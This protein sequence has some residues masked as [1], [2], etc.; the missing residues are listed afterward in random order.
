MARGTTLGRLVTMLREECGHATSAALAQNQ[1]PHVK[2]VL[3]RIQE[4]LWTDH[5]WEHLK[6]RRD[7]PLMAGQR[8]YS[9]PTD[10]AFERI[11]ALKVEVQ[12]NEQFQPVEYGIGSEQYNVSNPASDDRDAPVRRWQHY[13]GE[14]GE[15]ASNQYEVWPMPEADDEQIL[16]FHGIRK[17]P[18]LV[19]DADRAALDDNLIVLFAAV[20]FLKDEDAKKKQAAASQLYARL[21]GQH[22]KGSVIIMGG[23]RDPNM[24]KFRPPAPLYGRRST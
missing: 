21:K 15:D 2:R 11:S 8:Y 24:T 5:D 1:L 13:A 16:R 9:F 4:S 20:E 17:L 12:Y 14:E 23:G 7:E 10:L 19:A 3:A 6:I 22:S 18:A